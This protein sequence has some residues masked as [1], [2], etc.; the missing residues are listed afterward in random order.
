[1][2]FKILFF[3]KKFIADFSLRTILLKLLY[4]AKRKFIALK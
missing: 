1:M 3:K 2:N 4:K